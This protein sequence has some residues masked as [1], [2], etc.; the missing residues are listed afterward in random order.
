MGQIDLL[1]IEM[2]ITGTDEKETYKKYILSQIKKRYQN[3]A[4]YEDVYVFVVDYLIN[5]FKKYDEKRGSKKTFIFFKLKDAFKSWETQSDR[6]HDDDIDD[7]LFADSKNIQHFVD[8]SRDEPENVLVRKEEHEDLVN[9]LSKKVGFTGSYDVKL[10]KILKFLA[11]DRRSMTKGDKE[12]RKILI[13]EARSY[14]V[15]E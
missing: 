15:I 6:L 3:K 10:E 5:H 14:L 4:N 11:S 1:E 12:V 2:G 7:D 9:H 13:Q 8:D